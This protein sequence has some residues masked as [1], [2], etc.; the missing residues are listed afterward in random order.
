MTDREDDRGASSD[1]AVASSG[2][3]PSPPTQPLPAEPPPPPPP[4]ATQPLPAEP[5]GSPPGR[6]RILIGVLVAL[7]LFGGGFIVAQFFGGE[8]DSRIP[9]ENLVLYEPAGMVFPVEGAAFTRSTYDP[10]TKTCNKELLKRYLRGDE[11]RFAAWLELVDIRRDQFD[12]F[13]DQLETR[14]LPASLPVTNHGCF[15]EGEGRCWFAIQSVLAPGT[16]VWY[17]PTTREVIAKCLC[18]NPIDPPKCP[19]NCGPGGETA[20]A[21]PCVTETPPLE[22]RPPQTERPATEAPRTD[23]PFTDEPAVTDPPFTESPPT[24]RPPPEPP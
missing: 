14:I 21:C 1:E 22:T 2:P 15:R 7:V 8:T 9:D 13:V 4:T 5:P 23:P 11:R 24:E 10:D 16:P 3:E 17:N 6:N 18:S 20:T 12:G 19:P